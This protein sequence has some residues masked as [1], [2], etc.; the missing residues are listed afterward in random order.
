MKT[1]FIQY[2][3]EGEDDEK[4]VKTLKNELKLIKPGKLQKLNV[5]ECEITDAQLRILKTGTAVVLVFDTDT[6][7]A[8]GI[9][10]KNLEKL[11]NCKNVSEIITI[12]QVSNLEDELVRSCNIKHAPDLLNSASL[13][14]YKRDL[15]RTSN[16]AAKLIEHKFDVAR[17]WSINP[18]VPYHEIQNLSQKIKL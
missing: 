15:L 1:K 5:V 2:Y 16:L 12:P 14:D 18:G 10:N 8:L 7:N 13:K 11:R 3:V 9:L 4:I 6:K 17:F